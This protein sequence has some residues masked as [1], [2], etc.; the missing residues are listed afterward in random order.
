MEDFLSNRSETT[1][2]ATYQPT[3][4]IAIQTLFIVN[5]DNK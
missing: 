5:K 1:N 3:K 2:A 4:M